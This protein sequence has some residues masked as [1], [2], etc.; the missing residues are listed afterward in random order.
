M[1]IIEVKN[2]RKTYK[3][4]EKQEG[5]LGYFKNL[6]SPKYKEFTAVRGI[7]FNIEEGVSRIYRGKGS[8]EINY[9]KN[10]YRIINSYIWKSFSKRIN[11]K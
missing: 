7:N 10:A 1:A 3:I 5:L 11:T 4:I 9:N 8:R 2:L 6:I